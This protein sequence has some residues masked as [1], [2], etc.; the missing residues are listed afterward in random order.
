[1]EVSWLKEK[2]KKALQG[3]GNPVGRLFRKNNQGANKNIPRRKP[4]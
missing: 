2:I 4:C 1:M 3:E